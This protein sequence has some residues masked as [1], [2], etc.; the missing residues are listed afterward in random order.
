MWCWPPS[1]SKLFQVSLKYRELS[2][3]I[4]F[5]AMCCICGYFWAHSSSSPQ[6][7]C[8]IAVINLN[9]KLCTYKTVFVCFFSS[10]FVI[11][12]KFQNWEEKEIQCSKLTQ[13]LAWW[14]CMDSTAACTSRFHIRAPI[15]RLC[16]CFNLTLWTSR[17][18]C[19]PLLKATRHS[20]F[21][22]S[23]AWRWRR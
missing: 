22:S 7:C 2:Q 16:F 18:Y 19:V 13:C 6:K 21:T 1:P 11:P 14:Y 10:F 12:P 5:S 15:S 8:V 9:L 3:K 4:S 20:G 23:G 17:A